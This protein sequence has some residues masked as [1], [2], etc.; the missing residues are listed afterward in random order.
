[1][2]HFSPEHRAR[3]SAAKMGP[4]PAIRFWSKVNKQTESGCWTWAAGKSDGY[5]RFDRRAAHKISWEWVNGPVPDGLELD[6]LC[7][8]RACV[9]PSHLEA[10]DHKTNVRRGALPDLMR[11]KAAAQTHCYAGHE[12][13]GENL[14]LQGPTKQFRTCRTCRARRQRERYA[15]SKTHEQINGDGK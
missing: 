8:N 4:I 14:V 9:N 2:R 1:M 5:G 13:S 15:R 12:L 3:I 11:A 7:R 6:H 10:V